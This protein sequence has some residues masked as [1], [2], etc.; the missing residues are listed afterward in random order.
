[1]AV[2]CMASITGKSRADWTA[3]EYNTGAITAGVLC[4]GTA[5]FAI[6]RFNK[7]S[8]IDRENGIATDESRAV[9]GTGLALLAGSVVCGI[10]A[11]VWHGKAERMRGRA[12]AFLE[13]EGEKVVLSIPSPRY[14]D[15][16]WGADLARFTF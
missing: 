11:Y 6:E 1:M 13:M 12:G 14:S 15:G 10:T 8:K 16:L 5:I 4:L 7:A 9:G 3:D 2:L